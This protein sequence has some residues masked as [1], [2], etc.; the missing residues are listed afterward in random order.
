MHV[1]DVVEQRLS[2]FNQKT[3]DERVA[4]SCRES[5]QHLCIVSLGQLRQVVHQA[6]VNAT[7][8]DSIAHYLLEQSI[9]LDV[10]ENR[11]SGS[12]G[13]VLFESKQS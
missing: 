4:L 8:R 11:W 9:P 7:E 5:F 10:L 1:H 13:W 6:R 12:L 2:C 3:G